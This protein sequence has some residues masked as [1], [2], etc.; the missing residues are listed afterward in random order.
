MYNTGATLQHFNPLPPCGGRPLQ[1]VGLSRRPRFQ[2]TP[3][4]WRE[5]IAD[6]QSF[7]TEIIFQSTPSV[8]RETTAP[9]ALSLTVTDFNPLPPC[10]GRQIQI[11]LYCG[12]KHFNPLP[13]CGGRRFTFNCLIMT[14]IHFNPLP[15]CGGRR[16]SRGRVGKQSQFQSTPSVWRETDGM[17][18]HA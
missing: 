9:F 14:L 8:W 12:Q 3:S 13:P 5:T 18:G 7:W 1:I 16:I 6:I 17:H 2:S 15:P 10:G 11:P 4:V